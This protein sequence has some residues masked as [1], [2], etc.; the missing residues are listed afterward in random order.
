MKPVRMTWS[1]H[2][3]CKSYVPTRMIRASCLLVLFRWRLDRDRLHS[4]Q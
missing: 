1:Y 4:G 3:R 2:P